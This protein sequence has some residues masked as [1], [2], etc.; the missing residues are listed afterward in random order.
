[1]LLSSQMRM[2]RSWVAGHEGCTTSD[3]RRAIGVR[4]V[5]LYLRSLNTAW[6]LSKPSKAG[7]AWRRGSWPDRAT[8]SYYVKDEFMARVVRYVWDRAPEITDEQF[9]VWKASPAGK[10]SSA[11]WGEDLVTDE[12]VAV[13]KASQAGKAL[14][15][16]QDEDLEREAAWERMFPTPPTSTREILDGLG[17]SFMKDLLVILEACG[18]LA[19]ED[20]RWVLSDRARTELA[21]SAVVTWLWARRDDVFTLADLVEAFTG[22]FVGRRLHH[23]LDLGI[24][25]GAIAVTIDGRYQWQSPTADARG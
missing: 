5:L 18:E 21:R 10:T 24:Q 1:M 7:G 9:A 16:A 22:K 25:E 2:V 19:D 12:R 11:S 3:V 6:I 15:V 13:W 8:D 23:L 4:V 14:S 17:P 20:G